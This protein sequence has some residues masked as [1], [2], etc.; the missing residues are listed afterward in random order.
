MLNTSQDILYLTVAACV[1]AFTVT[2]IWIMYYIGQITKQSNDMLADFR[3][4]LEELDETVKTIQTKV[5]HSV[6]AL[7]AISDQVAY[8]VDF[9]RNMSKSKKRA[10]N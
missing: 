10:K 2:L 4:K 5:S 8:V 9:I 1:A 7:S 6:E 3:K